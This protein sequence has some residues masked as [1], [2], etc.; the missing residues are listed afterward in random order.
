LND[1]LA[2]KQGQI[3]QLVDSSEK[4]FAAFASEDSN[5]SRA[6][7]DLPATLQQTTTTLA[8][9]Q[10]FANILGPAATN[11]LPAAASIP[12]ANKALTALAVPGAPIVK[13]QIRPFVVASRPLVRNL[14]PAAVNLADSTVTQTANG[15]V[16]EAPATTNLT[17]AF[18]VLNHFGNMLGYNPGDTEHGYLWWLAWLDHNART[19]FSV[20]DANGDFRP[21]FLQA[22]CATMAQIANN[23]PLQEVIMNLTPILTSA[24]LCPAQAAADA[25]AYSKYQQQHPGTAAASSNSSLSGIQALQPH[26]GSGSASNGSVPKSNT[27]FLPKLPIN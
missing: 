26:A 11:L 1:A 24:N 8:K 18:T 10:A 27:L 15:P 5:V 20:Q 19:L 9:V 7:A 25:R 3:V 2:A 4:V 13:N 23:S 12:A 14:K 16:N 17:N 6:V 22:S 21:L